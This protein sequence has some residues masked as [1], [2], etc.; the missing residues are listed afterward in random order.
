MIIIYM[1]RFIAGFVSGL[2]IGTHYECKPILEKIKNLIHD[3]LPKE[4]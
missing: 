4:K 2:Y 1:L 3:N